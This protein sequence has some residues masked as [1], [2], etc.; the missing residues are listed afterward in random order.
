MSWSRNLP[1]PD[2]LARFLGLMLLAW[3]P[4]S[5]GARLPVF[6]LLLLG[7]WMLWHR[8][9]DFADGAV[10]RWGLLFLLLFVPV[11]M[12]IPL[13]FE[14]QGSALVALSLAA[15]YLI[16][17][18]LLRGLETERG[19]QW[20]QRWLLVVLLVWLADAYI[21][22]LFGRDL[23]GIPLSDD[24]RI[25]GPFSQNL[26][27][28]PFL[29]LMLPVA[30]ADLA[31][32]RPWTTLL[33]VALIGFV[34]AQSG[35][36]SSL[37]FF[38]LACATLLPRFGRSFRWPIVALFAAALIAAATVIVPRSLE[39][40]ATYG[41]LSGQSE[42][43]LIERLDYLSSIRVTI[44]QNGLRML[45]DRPITGVGA[46]AFA[47]AYPRYAPAEDFYIKHGHPVFH[48]HHMYV[49]IAAETGLIGL[50][51]FLALIGLCLR[52]YIRAPP[53]RRRAAA[54]FG[55]P[56]LVVAFPL[57]SQPVLFSIW[58][59]PVL[60][61]FLCAMLASL[62]ESPPPPIDREKSP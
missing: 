40:I 18:A 3:Q 14:P 49:S 23:L 15:F 9:I 6:L 31:E 32:R 5:S 8:R 34:C 27:L 26:H 52:W 47:E 51:G 4:F 53:E 54:P 12:S 48:A 44:W 50:T 58:W 42:P 38:L 56:L 16:G 43:T 2:T 24:G 21:Q 11:A 59:F 46:N 29:V 62:R 37:I 13:S 7:G 22:Y 61:L 41:A 39:R 25:V 20:L 28:G 35:A 60:L 55:A 19:R 30:L 36:R 1:A 10:K 17:L 45:A 57:Q 33:I